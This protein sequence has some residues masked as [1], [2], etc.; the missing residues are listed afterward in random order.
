METRPEKLRELRLKKHSKFSWAVVA[1][2]MRNLRSTGRVSV[3]V[4]N[5]SFSI[6][7]VKQAA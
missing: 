6:G 3:K 5:G 7:R 1:R 2:S 4:K